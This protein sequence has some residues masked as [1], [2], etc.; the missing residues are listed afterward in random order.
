MDNHLA[1]RSDFGHQ[2]FGQSDDDL[3]PAATRKMKVLNL[4][5][6][7]HILRGGSEVWDHGLFIQ[8]IGS[9]WSGQWQIGHNES[10][11]SAYSINIANDQSL[12]HN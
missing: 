10:A 6:R 9:P 7:R 4:E 8:R 2:R 1:S 3:K 5:M 12:F 11:A